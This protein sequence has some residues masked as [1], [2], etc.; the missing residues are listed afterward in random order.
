MFRKYKT[1]GKIL[2]KNFEPEDQIS[3]IREKPTKTN[4]KGKI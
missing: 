1:N 4:I 3:T 2:K